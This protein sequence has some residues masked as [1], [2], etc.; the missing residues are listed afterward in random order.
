MP[1]FKPRS[2]RLFFEGGGG[3]GGGVFHLHNVTLLSLKL[4]NI[5]L[6]EK[7]EFNK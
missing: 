7:L 4:D 6:H 2:T 3:G 5:V 1:F